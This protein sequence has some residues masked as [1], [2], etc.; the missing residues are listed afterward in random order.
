M[1][2]AADA[3]G[4]ATRKFPPTLLVGADER[5]AVMREEIFGPVLPV[6]AYDSLDDAIAYVN[7]HPRPLALYWFGTSGE[8]R[9]RV[10]RE[11]ISGGVAINDACWHVCPGIPAVRWRRRERHGR[12]SWRAR[13]P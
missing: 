12:L 2:A 5:M 8:H 4:A 1:V 9:D 10:L 3:H 6:I 13:L 11:T 7:R